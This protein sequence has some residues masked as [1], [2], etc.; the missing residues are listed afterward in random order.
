MRVLSLDVHGFKSFAQST[1][2]EFD[3]GI[4]GIVGPNGSG[5][6]NVV[7]AVRWVLG[8][9]SYS[10]LRGKR[11]ED[12]IWSGT[13]GRAATGMAEVSITF[14]NSDRF[15]PIEYPEVTITRRAYRSGENEY[16]INRSRVRLRDIIALVSAMGQG[17][18][19]VSQGTADAA[20]SLTPENRRSLFEEAADI[21]QHYARRDETLR[22]F[23][24]MQTNATRVSDLLAEFAPRLCALA[25]QARQAREREA[26]E[27]SMRDLQLAYYSHELARSQHAS[28]TA[29]QELAAAEQDV[30]NRR[31][32]S[33]A[34]NQ[35]ELTFRQSV[36]AAETELSRMDGERALLSRDE[37][38]RERALRE[39]EYRAAECARELAG[40]GSR[41]EAAT[42]V[43]DATR[44]ALGV[45][46]SAYEHTSAAVTL[47]RQELAE[48][49]QREANRRGERQ[50]ALAELSQLR[51]EAHKHEEDT[52]QARELIHTLTE[53][54]ETVEADHHTQAKVLEEQRSALD[55]GTSSEQVF[56]A[57]A[58]SA[59]EAVVR[60]DAAVE[61]V[62]HAVQRS[63]EEHARLNTRLVAARAEV[64][65]KRSRHS[66]LS[67]MHH[68]GAG[69]N[70][71]AQAVVRASANHELAGIVGTLG[72]VIVVPERLE[73][74][75]ESA[76][77]AAL[78]NVV[79]RHWADAEQAIALLKRSG[80]GRVTFLPLDT[81]R[82]PTRPGL[83]AA[84]GIV[85]IA[86]ELV[87]AEPQ[88][89]PALMHALGRVLIVEDLPTA[90]SIVQ[91]MVGIS[92]VV[93]LG[94]ETLR[95][96]GSLTGGAPV[97][98]SGMLARERE[99]R[100]LPAQ[101]ERAERELQETAHA[102]RTVEQN[103]DALAERERRAQQEQQA[104]VHAARD[105]GSR[106]EGVRREQDRLRQREEWLRT[107]VDR[108]ATECET[109]R[110]R[111]NTARDNQRAGEERASAAS[112]TLER[113]VH[114]AGA[115]EQDSW[116][117]ASL[118]AA[119]RTGLAVVEERLRSAQVAR[120]RA[121]ET[122]RTTEAEQ[123]RHGRVVTAGAELAETAQ[124]KMRECQERLVPVRARLRELDQY[125]EPARAVL[126]TQRQELEQVREAA[127]QASARAVQG[128]EARMHA[129]LRV[130]RAEDA[131][132][133][134]LERAARETGNAEIPTGLSAPEDV[135]TRIQRTAD[136]LARIGPVNALAAHEHNEIKERA[137]FLERQLA[138]IQ[139][140]QGNLQRLIGTIE[141]QME[142]RFTET[143]SVVSERFGANFAR[144]FNGGTAQ[145]ALVSKGD[146]VG[147]EIQAQPPGKR[148][149]NL[150]L[151]SGGERALTSCALL[152]ALIQAG[153][154]PFCVLDEVDAALDES[155]IGRF[156]DLLEELARDTQFIVVTHNRGTI[157]R[158]SR[159][160]GVSM[161]ASGISKVLSLQ[162]DEAEANRAT[163]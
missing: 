16:M 58:Q 9:Q 102:L 95:P 116:D 67:E 71:G 162:L 107:T 145:L 62:R 68:S 142:R 69:L 74:A 57:A 101:I 55:A 120:T 158:A 137:D 66:L 91:R 92:A 96:G 82:P 59:R 11:T 42:A 61:E 65:E 1:R 47:A 2:L 3:E 127:A 124:R 155:N 50:V 146:T 8:E 122:L 4:A 22:R 48:V 87:D 35:K 29:R 52:R 34:C 136:R 5:K 12:V 128:A 110:S 6:S 104:A 53:R 27:Q 106:L 93:T 41:H 160:Y 72:S 70:R 135:E 75:V 80:A 39:A 156:C 147:V 119:L 43:V 143:F 25:R 54:L 86:A 112:R 26:E 40:A 81:L 132:A 111:L 148:L 10:Q 149:G 31:A 125:I 13:K 90:R 141:E 17:Y 117:A 28:N 32:E 103:R 45:A 131:H 108:A 113:A 129:T 123:V 84:E 115:F 98:E 79:T 100:V 140:A 138:D 36:R 133:G 153:G 51:A 159:L 7:E 99:L 15:L 89:R 38:T 23:T 121:Q 109:L 21:T 85:G 118:L 30:C 46:A 44:K 157:E 76:L 163:A 60:A 105:A 151:L 63:S 14:D 154:A 150:S 56:D 20:L 24:E 94:G 114:T 77:G 73:Q 78:Q 126:R 19:V 88:I 97:R 130:Q 144:L 139:T 161:E 33:E 83:P 49:E 152:F 18:T 37:D 134:L 64:R